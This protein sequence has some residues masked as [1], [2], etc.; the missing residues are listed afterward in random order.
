MKKWIKLV[1]GLF[2]C[3]LLLIAFLPTFLSTHWGKTHF[4]N[5][6][7]SR[8]PGKLVIGK[9][10]LNWIGGQKL[11]NL[12]LQDSEG[13][14]LATLDSLILDTSLGNLL[15][16]KQLEHSVTLTGLNASLTRDTSGSTNLQRAL[17]ITLPHLQGV[18]SPISLELKD[19]RG[20][21]VM[22]NLNEP[23]SINLH[24]K[25]LQ[26]GLE[27]SF[28]IEA[29]LKGDQI[30]ALKARL[31]NLPIALL[32]QLIVL[33]YAQY[34]GLATAA[35]GEMLDLDIEQT[36]T[37]AGNVINMH[38]KSPT[39]QADLQ[40]ELNQEIFSLKNPLT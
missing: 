5:Y 1:A 30:H 36:K 17:G 38:L 11:H 8:I 39:L 22:T 35:L 31:V 18:N 7:N 2:I 27:G 29:L 14:T 16:S 32:D 33:R 23:V 12:T 6:A 19:G 25:T 40:G 9:L 34:A 21:I 20:Q 15:W 28:D 13:E 4:V 24:G 10:S 26:S 3:L 37:A